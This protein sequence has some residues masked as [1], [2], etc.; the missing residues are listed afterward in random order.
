MINPMYNLSRLPYFEKWFLLGLLLGVIAGLSSLTFYF[1]I[2]LAEYLFLKQIVGLTL[3]VPLGEGG[4]LT[5]TFSAERFYLI[6][7]VTAIGGGISGL[8]VYTFAPEAEGHGTDAAISA[9]HNKQ[10]KIRWRVVPIKLI[11]SAITIGSGGSAGREG[12]TAQLSAGLGSILADLLQLSPE[13]R[14]R[15]VAVGIGAG[16]GTI[17]KTPI[18]GAL[19]ASEILYK[20]DMEP[21]VIY[22]ALVASAIGYSIFGSVVGFTP[23][24]GNYVEPFDPLR[25]PLYAVLGIAAG[26]VGILYI[27]TFYKVTNIFR[28]L[29]VSNYLKPVIGA[30]SMGLIA[31]VFPEVIATG[32]GWVDLLEFNKLNEFYTIGIPIILLLALLPFVKII[33]TSLT[34]GSGGSG[35]VFAPGIF[36]GA[37]LG[38]DIGLLF[39]ILFPTL[40]PSI[41]PFVIIGMVSTFGGAAKAPLSV[42]VMV[43]EMTGSFQLLPGAMI[44]V[45]I[46]YLITG[47][48]T[49]YKSQVPTRKES[50]AHA[51]EY[52]QP[53]MEKL[54]VEQCNL[55]KLM[56]RPSDRVDNALELMQKNLVLSLPVVTEDNK[57]QGIVYMRDIINKEGTVEK[58]AH[59][60]VPSVRRTSTLE[61][62]LDVM[63]RTKSRWAP[64]V[65]KGEF[66][67]IIT[68]EE[69][70]SLYEKEIKKINVNTTE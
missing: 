52:E 1:A 5:Y 53:V 66:F 4:S 45:A 32:Y 35:G 44:A 40:V 13:D 18:G 8:L 61:D 38:G 51:R 56:I 60:G 48:N 42:M 58:Y 47:N 12:P 6:P 24:F 22:P 30:F 67:G 17:F 29:R 39:H 41:A 2:R 43:T 64:V 28:R 23:I 62:A 54:R 59:S 65:E 69:I 15:A 7:L 11:A 50:P 21:E 57:F 27:K 55:V 70:T 19:L 10:G 14:R 26:L 37:F 16:I 49:I 63:A 33:A 25:L 36:I 31:L 68:M 9:Y 46:A 3:P 34:I 20:R